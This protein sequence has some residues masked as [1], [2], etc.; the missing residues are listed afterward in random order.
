[1]SFFKAA[2]NGRFSYIAKILPSVL[3]CAAVPLLAMLV[4]TDSGLSAYDWFSD[5]GTEADFFLICKMAAIVMLA[6]VMTSVMVHGIFVKKKPFHYPGIIAVPLIIYAAAVLLSWMLGIHNHSQVVGG[7]AQHETVFVLLAYVVFLLYTYSELS[8]KYRKRKMN[9]M[10]ICLIISSFVLALIGL[11]QFLQND[12]LLGF[13][14]KNI[15]TLFSGINPDRVR[16]SFP[17]GTV[18]MT[19][20]NPNYVGSYVSL[21]LPVVFAGTMLIKKPLWKI[22][23]I[24]NS[25]M[26]IVCLIGS[27]SL[28]G[29]ISTVSGALVI[30]ITVMFLKINKRRV[31]I[32]YGTV[33]FC[34]FLA[35]VITAGV[36]M[37]GHETNEERSLSY[38]SV[39]DENVTVVINENEY[40]IVC[41]SKGGKDVQVYDKNMKRL[42]LIPEKDGFYKANDFF[43]QTGM[44]AEK[45]SG[46]NI[47]CDDTSYFFTNDNEE[48]TYKFRTPY[49]KYTSDIA[50]SPEVSFLKTREAFASHRGY[51]WSHTIPLIKKFI[52]YGCGPDNFIY[53]FPNNDYPDIIG[54]NYSGQVVTRPHNMY[55][56]M[57]VQT[58]LVS[59]LAFVLLYV[60]YFVN[61]V[62][63]TKMAG[64]I[65]RY[66]VISLALLAGATGYMVSGLANDSTVCVAPVYFTLLG[67]GFAYNKMIFDKEKM[68][69]GTY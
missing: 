3:A 37:A 4:V 24:I 53:V 19:L 65:T 17:A 11:S 31:R 28:T 44:S 9:L 23:C 46:F 15:I 57:A 49:G 6:I 14:I 35:A 56:Q 42:L 13:P 12:L 67:L 34:A 38:M 63:A 52:L 41:D 59:V 61:T 2:F 16:L 29:I 18:Y 27:G 21:I 43:V 64:R 66:S 8:G 54:N 51:I 30:G 20:Y 69:N 55:L 36:Y 7:F 62:S 48:G 50:N 33:V 1:M 32:I 10:L 39:N 45:K 58:G 25:V 22:F 5:N 60:L 68:K 26:L 47:I 40:H